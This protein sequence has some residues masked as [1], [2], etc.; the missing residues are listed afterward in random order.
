[1]R[2]E[3]KRIGLKITEK[4]VDSMSDLGKTLINETFGLLNRELDRFTDRSKQ[5]ITSKDEIRKL[6]GKLRKGK[7][8]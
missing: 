7:I 6:Q 1:M 8:F 3:F 4:A 2:D 5:V